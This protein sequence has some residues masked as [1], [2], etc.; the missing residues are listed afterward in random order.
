M[1]EALNSLPLFLCL[2][3][4]I[5]S[6][7]AAILGQGG[8]LILMT[9]LVGHFPSQLLIP[10]H[11]AIQA[12]SNGSRAFLALPHIKWPIILPVIAGTIIGALIITPFI[13]SLNWQWLQGIIAIFIL[14][15]T[16]GNGINIS[17]NFKGALPFLGIIQGAL[18]MALGA[19]GPLGNALLLKYGLNKHQLVASNAV[20]MFTSHIMKIIIFTLIGTQL[21]QYWQSILALC[22]SSVLGSFAGTPLRHKLPGKYFFP[23]FKIILTLLALR[24][25]INAF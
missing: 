13:P 17:R 4:F 10:I 22:I 14:W 7:F 24:M 20:I 6:A 9:I 23:L 18:G 11:G 5:C 25:L 19:T 3:A 2:A 16:W 1:I 12:S 21:I 15:M 8:G